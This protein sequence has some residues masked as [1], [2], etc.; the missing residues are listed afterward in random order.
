[1][2]DQLKDPLPTS[3]DDFGT[4]ERIS[5]SKLDNKYL[6]VLDD[7][8]ELEFDPATS[9]W[10]EP[11]D[12]P[13]DPFNDEDETAAQLA[14]LSRAG[15]GPGYING[16]GPQ[17]TNSRKRKDSPTSAEDGGSINAAQGEAGGN[18]NGKVRPAKKAKPARAPPQPRQNTA[19]YV[20]G[21]PADATV[22]EVHEVFSRKAGV[23]AEEIDSGRPRIKMYTDEM[24]NFKGDALVVFFKPQSVEMA[25]MLLDDTEFRF[26][27]G[28]GEA[29]KMRVQAADSSY[30]KVKYDE[31]GAEGAGGTGGKGGDNGEGTS[32]QPKRE[33]NDRDRQ[34]II[35]KTQKMAAKLA[36]WSDDDTAAIPTETNSKWDKTVI[37]KH[38]FTLAELEEDPAAL[39]EIKEDIREECAKLGNV[40]NVVLYDEEPDGVVSVKFSQP[41]S[42]Q[43]CI[44]LMNGRSFDGRVVEASTATGRERFKKSKQGQ[45]SDSE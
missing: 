34:K 26:E 14:D 40:T 24:G 21:L 8:T 23:I 31:N 28:T 44:Q 15:A 7:G 32:A 37:L 22:D 33:R 1:M 18:G 35:R 5:F 20:T 27:P 38:M 9:T 6:A 17:Q 4:D 42:A 29:P 41:Q 2:T 10:T 3:V 19:V 45:A 30:K 12:V 39:L 25:I 36:D 11:A 43:A 16:E 13:L